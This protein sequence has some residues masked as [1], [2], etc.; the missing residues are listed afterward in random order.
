MI[1]EKRKYLSVWLHELNTQGYL[2][3][4]SSGIERKGSWDRLLIEELFELRLML[5]PCDSI[6]KSI[7][8][9]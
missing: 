2:L 9:K 3:V 5:E 1:T 8:S 4:V 7:E 6:S